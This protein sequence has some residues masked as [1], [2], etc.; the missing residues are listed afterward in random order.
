MNPR[1]AARVVAS[2]ALVAVVAGAHA[3]GS[4]VA[5]TLNSVRPSLPAAL[6]DRTPCVSD[7]AQYHGVNPWVLK[8]ILKV[9]S[10]FNPRAINRNANSSVDVGMGQMNSIHFKELSGFGIAPA[11][12]LDGCVATYIAAWHLAKQM[13]K[14]GNTWYGIASYHSAT[15]CFNGRYAGLLWNTLVSWK[16]LP[17]PNVRVPRIEECGGGTVAAVPNVRRRPSSNAAV[18][19]AYDIE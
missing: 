9:E 17:G 4:E 15:P 1:S 3:N 2:A 13:R 7:A 11:H 5:A 6:N 12:L 10:G 19:V 8:A 18:S 16:V 14:H